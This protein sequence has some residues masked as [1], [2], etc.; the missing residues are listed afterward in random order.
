MG[1]N[2]A[3]APLIAVLYAAL[4]HFVGGFLPYS[5]GF[6]QAL[7]LTA[8]ASSVTDLLLTVAW[9]LWLVLI[10]SLLFSSSSKEG[11]GVMLRV[12][13]AFLGLSWVVPL[14]NQLLLGEVTGVMTKT[15]T[16]FYLLQGALSTAIILLLCMMLFRKPQQG[17]KAPPAA[18]QRFKLR[19]LSLVIMLIVLPVFYFIL[20]FVAGYFL[21]WSNDAAR[22]Y[23]GGGADGGFFYM[24]IEML[25]SHIKYGGI[26]LLT[27]LLTALFAL[28]VMTLLP[29]RRTV[30]VA[31]SAMLCLSGGLYY[32][33][34]SP[35]MPFAIRITHLIAL[36]V[37]SL[38]YGAVAGV[39]LHTCYARTETKPAPPARD[40]DRRPAAAGG[41]RA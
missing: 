2:F 40:P 11:A 19:P 1:G 23:Y 4:Y 13:P 5:P 31:S 33:L 21:G 35:V 38:V 26:A 3:K 27:G 12:L 7:D 41:R 18:S 17:G 6:G 28:P 32:L 15:D 9:S 14:L 36:G 37:V 10:A 34:P 39:L 29:D 16:A 24:L 30:F 20:F 22:A 25:I 8:A